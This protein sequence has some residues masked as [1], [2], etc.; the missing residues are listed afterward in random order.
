LFLCDD[1][2]THGTDLWF[3]KIY[4]YL[5]QKGARGIKGASL[6]PRPLICRKGMRP[7]RHG[8]EQEKVYRP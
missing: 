5:L 1:R 2:S 8:R 4:P 3:Q 7:R 6:I